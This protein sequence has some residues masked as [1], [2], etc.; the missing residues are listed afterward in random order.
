MTS[1]L[2]VISVLSVHVISHHIHRFS[3]L[4]YQSYLFI[5]IFMVLSNPSFASLLP[6]ADQPEDR[7]TGLREPWQSM[8]GPLL[9][10][11]GDG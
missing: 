9:S 1:N 5:F 3:S 6:S 10:I 7:A 4:P 11:E 2:I 8:S